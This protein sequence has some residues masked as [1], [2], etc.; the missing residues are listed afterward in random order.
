MYTDYSKTIKNHCLKGM[1]GFNAELLK[2]NNCGGRGDGL[3]SP[4]VP[5]LDIT[6]TEQH[7]WGRADHHAIAGYFARINYNY[8]EKYL[9]E[10]NGRYDGSSRFIGDKRWGFFPSAS[11]GWNIAKERFFNNAN[12]YI[13]VLK[14]RA[15]W[16][17]VERR[18]VG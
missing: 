5:Y 12:K 2:S 13:S 18:I 14:L 15:P 1:V 8:K 10:L 6:T 17:L 16:G 7:V 9:L 3:I 4:S 11:V